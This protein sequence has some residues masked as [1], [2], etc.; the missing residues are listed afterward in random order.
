MWSQRHGSWISRLLCCASHHL[1][2]WENKIQRGL[3]QQESDRSTLLWFMDSSSPPHSMVL[4]SSCCCWVSW[5]CCCRCCCA[6]CWCVSWCCVWLICVCGN[7]SMAMGERNIC[8]EWGP[9]TASCWEPG[10]VGESSMELGE[11]LGSCW[12]RMGCCWYG[13]GCCVGCEVAVRSME[14]GERKIWLG[15][16]DIISCGGLAGSSTGCVLTPPGEKT[17]NQWG[18]CCLTALSTQ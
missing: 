2:F 14:R 9:M 3:N 1:W 13:W 6:S 16:D 8:P 12:R 4:T 7:I 17:A 11:M 5:C 18:R 15:D 10:E